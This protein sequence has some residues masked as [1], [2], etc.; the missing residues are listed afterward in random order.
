MRLLG[1]LPGDVVDVVSE[2]TGIPS[3]TITKPYGITRV[4]H[5]RLLAYWVA[6]QHGCS[7]K[8]IGR[9]L[10]RDYTAV[11]SGIRRVD[12]DSNLKALAIEVSQV[13]HERY[14]GRAREHAEVKP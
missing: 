10:N 6:H 3:E 14:G 9:W 12:S 2:M 4:Q 13:V 11:A 5:A 1:P 7:L 8:E